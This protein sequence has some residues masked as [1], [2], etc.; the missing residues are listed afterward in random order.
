MIEMLLKIFSSNKN[1]NIYVLKT[2][3][4]CILLAEYV[5]LLCLTLSTKFGFIERNNIITFT[6]LIT[7]F[8]F[9][10][11]AIFIAIIDYLEGLVLKK[12]RKQ[13]SSWESRKQKV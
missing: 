7:I 2:I 6:F 13:N 12:T 4:V 10:I 1:R 3:L 5:I 11:T 8:A 9:I